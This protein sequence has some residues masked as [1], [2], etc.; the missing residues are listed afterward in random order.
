VKTTAA[1][2]VPVTFLFLAAVSLTSPAQVVWQVGADDESWSGLGTGGGPNTI[3]VQENGSINDLPGDPN[4]PAVDR[5]A[6][7]DYYFAGVYTNTIPSVVAAYMDY[8]PVGD[9]AQNEQAAERAFAGSDNDWRVHFNLP[10]TLQTNDM[11]SVTWDVLNLDGSPGPNPFYGAQVFFNGL[12]IQPEIIVYQTNGFTTNYTTAQFSLAS[13][14]AQVGPGWDNIVSLKGVNHNADGGGNWMGI[15]YV[16]LDATLFKPTNAPPALPVLVTC[17]LKDNGWPFNA[18]NPGTGGGANTSFVQENG[19]I[20][21]LPGSPNSPAVD[22]QAD[23]DYYF[24]GSYTTAISS[25]TNVY[26]AYTPVGTVAANEQAAERSLAGEDNDLRYHFNLPSTLKPFDLLSVSFAPFNLD[27]TGLD[28]RY[29]VEVYI[30]G[31]LVGPQIL[32]RP[33]DLEKDYTTAQ[34][35][36]DAVN[37]QVG[38]GFDN[39]L[40]L[41]GY[42]QSADGGGN[43]LGIDYVALHAG[44]STVVDTNPPTVIAVTRYGDT[45]KIEVTFS[46]KVTAATANNIANYLLG[47]SNVITLAV[48]QPDGTNV[49]LTVG[50]MPVG[51]SDTLTVT[52]VKDIVGNAI[53][54][55]GVSFIFTTKYEILF[56]T[57]DAGPLTFPGDQAVLS[58]LQARGFDVTLTTGLAVPDD[59]SSAKGKDLVI[60]SS[61]LASSSVVAA[62]GGAKFL[63]SAVPVIV[64]EPGLED[65]FLFQPVAGTAYTNQTQIN[66]V[67]AN[68][69][70]AAGFPAG[71]LTVTTSPQTYSVGSPVGAHIVANSAPDATQPPQA[72]IYYYD[73]GDRGATNNFV[74]PARRVFFFF[75]DNTAAA[76]NAAGTKLF[77]A[78]VD[79]AM[80]PAVGNANPP[81]LPMLWTCGVHDN[82]WPFNAANPGTG[83]GA[84]T[85]F[86]QENGTINP[87]PGNPSS[88]AADTQA[89]NDYYFAGDYSLTISSVTNSYGDYTPVGTVAADEEAAERAFAGADNDLR[90]H[91][92]LPPSLKTNDMLSVT[93]A[94]YNLDGGHPDSRYGVAVYINSVLVQ[95]E[96]VIRSA[97]LEVDYTTP[98]VTLAS[99][100]A[101]TGAGYDNIVSLKGLNYSADGGGSW[102]GLDYV[103]LNGGTPTV[104]VAFL[105]PVIGSGKITLSWTGTGSLEWAPSLQG[106]WTAITPTPTSPYS[107]DIQPG[108][109]RF[110]RLRVQ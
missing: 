71:L 96:I 48:L 3:F 14:N 104:P 1:V 32:V 20:N 106:Q 9:V 57:Q 55:T 46:E 18:A 29:G 52:G 53:P 82:G 100:N 89:D 105:P 15:D 90:Y 36:L 11:L 43:S 25:V 76:V 45:A 72:L 19:T 69:P 60:I 94:E 23:N 65:D 91:F 97:Q 38:P 37:A 102:M 16:R 67:D 75:Q 87:L 47:S 44:A 64:W 59:G 110:Y 108:Q 61:S 35:R 92:N 28:P 21:P 68:S 26:G 7:N 80:V 83:G 107:E 34:I 33:V 101:Q 95:P 78:A 24:A 2:L 84:N 40:S 6:D 56:V 49:V 31:V 86:V 99:V 74:M 8:V 98:P 41:K 70:L 79:F 10:T 42:N 77:D 81:N 66:I 50:P 13:V 30:N 93:F 88:P 39:I 5:Q 12:E 17:G 85:S 109:N 58:R 54:S 73:K 103:Q 27:T 51:A 63:N 62:A 22:G 4:S